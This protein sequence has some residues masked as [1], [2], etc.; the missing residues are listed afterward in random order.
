MKILQAFGC[1]YCGMTSRRKSSVLRHEA[2]SCRKSP[3]RVACSICVWLDKDESGFYC[4]ED[5]ADFMW[6]GVNEN[7]ICEK[8]KHKGTNHE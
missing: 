1:S 3:N 4:E 7:R 8:F 5:A 6:D 2:Y